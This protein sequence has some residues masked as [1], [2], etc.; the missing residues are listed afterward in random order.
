MAIL[1]IIYA[2]LA[3]FGSGLIVFGFCIDVA[4]KIVHHELVLY[5]RWAFG[6]TMVACWLGLTW[7]VLG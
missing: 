4:E 1:K 3:L 7:A 6:I 5:A 2:I